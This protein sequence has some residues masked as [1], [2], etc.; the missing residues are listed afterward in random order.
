MKVFSS[1]M[2][3][4]FI[5]VLVVHVNKFVRDLER[6]E[7]MYIEPFYVLAKKFVMMD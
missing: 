2:Y 1:T 4:A 7:T 5:I 3:L 6:A